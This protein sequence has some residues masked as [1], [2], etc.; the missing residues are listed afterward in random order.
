MSSREQQPQYTYSLVD[1]FEGLVNP[2]EISNGRVAN[3]LNIGYSNV[4]IPNTFET[5]ADLLALNAFIAEKA[6]VHIAK[7]YGYTYFASLLHLAKDEEP[8]DQRLVQWRNFG[9]FESGLRLSLVNIL[10]D[11]Y[12]ELDTESQYLHSD[13]D[14]GTS[15]T[16][17]TR[18]HYERKALE[19]QRAAIWHAMQKLQASLPN[20]SRKKE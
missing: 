18:V 9:R 14:F 13:P 6:A 7:V 17:H 1:C 10:W 4:A 8:V 20:S 15:R 5:P 2:D 19:D 12:D 11:Q 3:I 16:D